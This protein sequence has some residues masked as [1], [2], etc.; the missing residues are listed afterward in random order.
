[1]KLKYFVMTAFLTAMA[2]VNAQ[3]ARSENV[4]LV[5]RTS[6]LEDS[7][8]HRRMNKDYTL[9]AQLTGFAVSPVPAAGVNFGL[10]L[11]RNSMLQAEFSKGTLPIYFFN[12]NATTLGANY[13][14]FFGNSFYGKIGMDYRSI[15]ASD[16]HTGYTTQ[17]G[18][19]GE[20]ESVVA[21]LAIG[22]QWQWE[23]FTMV[24]DWI[25]VNPP[26][27]VL[28]TTYNPGTNLNDSDRADLEK[29]WN[30]IAKVTRYQFLRF[31]LGASF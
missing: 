25:G 9:T 24:C 3:A 20:A 8:E 16:I 13:K 15:S 2:T 14:R 21:N 11:D 27:A 22:N 10:F 5:K 17:S 1:M 7:S 18:T 4:T 23:N 12:M 19:I 31:Y 30:N 26:I 28:K 29:S 6:I